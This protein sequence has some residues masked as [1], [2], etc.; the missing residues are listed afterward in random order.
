MADPKPLANSVFA[1]ACALTAAALR[2]A[3]AALPISIRNEADVA[4][5]NGRR[6]LE[7]AQRPDGF[8]TMDGR[9]SVL[10]AFAFLGIPSD[11]A[12]APFAAA[13][14]AALRRLAEHA[15]PREGT[16][17]QMVS[18]ASLGEDALVA[19]AALSFYGPGVFGDAAGAGAPPIAALSAARM[20]LLRLDAAAVSPASAWLC[21][22]ALDVLPG[23]TEQPEDWAPLFCPAQGR[24]GPAAQVG[25]SPGA[26]SR[27]PAAL[28]TCVAAPLRGC[29]I[30]GCAIAGY[31]RLRHG[32]GADSPA[33]ILAHLRWL[34]VHSGDLLSDASSA[35]TAEASPEDL[36]YAAVFLDAAPPAL[37]A[38]AG[39]PA[40]W[41]TR[42]AQRLIAT[43]RSDG[44]SG[45]VWPASGDGDEL[46]QTLYAVATLA[47]LGE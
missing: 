1:L 36:Y 24:E 18:A 33:A 10:P 26:P 45:A 17:A 2:P 37:V 44:Q 15:R 28:P 30:R 4:V 16:S 5:E 6:H 13:S 43:S 39:I 19:G 31:A 11:E 38:T 41:R 42:I 23:R 14:R 12:P 32:V 9:V 46:R 20:R 22:C 29:A 35:D 27:S 7:E 40:A 34:R 3:A 47:A 25:A 8:W 21:R